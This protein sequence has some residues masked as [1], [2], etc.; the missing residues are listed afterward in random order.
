MYRN[1]PCVDFPELF[2]NVSFCFAC[3]HSPSPADVSESSV[4]RRHLG[5]NKFKMRKKLD[6]VSCLLSMDCEEALCAIFLSLDGSTLA[7]CSLVCT[8]WHKFLRQKLWRCRKVRQVPWGKA[9]AAVEDEQGPRPWQADWGQVQRLW[10]RLRRRADS[11]A[12][13][14]RPGESDTQWKAIKSWPRTQK[15]GKRKIFTL[16]CS[17]SRSYRRPVLSW[18]RGDCD[19]EEWPIS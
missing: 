11:R 18:V 16:D 6:I 7:A 8:S 14:R 4:E 10:Y 12:D 1:L 2:H 15:I 19:C 17:T 5:K 9:E 13:G 3:Y